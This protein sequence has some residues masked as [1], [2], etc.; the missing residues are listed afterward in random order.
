MSKSH[1]FLLGGERT[2]NMIIFSL[3]G[4]LAVGMAAYANLHSLR[5]EK[6]HSYLYTDLA[7]AALDDLYKSG[8]LSR[9]DYLAMQKEYTTDDVV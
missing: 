7:V 9:E 6:T 5:N 4:I 3:I 2:L 1:H 8:K